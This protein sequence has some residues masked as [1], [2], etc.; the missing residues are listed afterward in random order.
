LA[1]RRRADARALELDPP[2]DLVAVLGPLPEDR[3]T[4]QAWRTAAGQVDGYRRAYGIPASR[5]A[6]HGWGVGRVQELDG[7]PTRGHGRVQRRQAG[8]RG[9]AE[10]GDQ[11][12]GLLGP[13]PT[14]DLRQRRAWLAARTAVARLRERT[15]DRSDRER[16]AG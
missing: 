8:G 5:R 2:A 3:R 6:E 11:L 10:R 12:T 14:G 15:H 9:Q 13:E 7:Y 1:W 16:E 4:R